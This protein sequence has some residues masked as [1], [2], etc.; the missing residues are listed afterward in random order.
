MNGEGIRLAQG[1]G[2]V[3]KGIN[4]MGGGGGGLR[5]GTPLYV[6]AAFMTSSA[7]ALDPSYVHI[8]TG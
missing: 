6:A 8:G 1:D 4:M 5:A 2:T 3:E 7:P